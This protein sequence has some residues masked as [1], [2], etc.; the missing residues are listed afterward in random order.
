M[1]SLIVGALI[2]GF[3]AGVLADAGNSQKLPMDDAAA[4]GLKIQTDAAVKTEGKASI[5][6]TTAWPTT[7]CLGEI[8]KLNVKG[9]K[10]IYRAEIKTE[11]E[12]SAFLEMWVQVGGGQYFSRGLDNIVSGKADWRSVRTIFLL[13]QN[14][15][16]E[17]ATLNLVI[18]G[19][20]TVW[21]DSVILAEENP[22]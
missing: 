18:N 3:M 12:G 19:K 15:K 10:L 9:A 16:A 17:K 1:K 5:K 4:L 8:A 6:I 21:I 2:F 22:Q 11:L 7:V 14:Q 13:P 20:G